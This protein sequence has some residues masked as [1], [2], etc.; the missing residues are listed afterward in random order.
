MKGRDGV[1]RQVLTAIDIALGLLLVI[2]LV[3]VWLLTASVEA[4]LGGEHAI[5]LPAMLASLA[6]FLAGAGLLKYILDLEKR[7]R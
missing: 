4:D 1:R 7:L 6:S 2:F 5:G 3:Q